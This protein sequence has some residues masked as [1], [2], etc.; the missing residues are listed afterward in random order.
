VTVRIVEMAGAQI[1]AE[2][3]AAGT[4][5]VPNVKTLAKAGAWT[6]NDPYAKAGLF[7]SV[8]IS[9]GRKVVG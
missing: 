9:G 6:A 8:M 3:Q 1:D 5:G 2:R 7:D 4:T